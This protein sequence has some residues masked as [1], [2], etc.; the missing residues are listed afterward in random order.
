MCFDHRVFRQV[1]VAAV[2]IADSLQAEPASQSIDQFVA[3]CYINPAMK[4][5]F[6]CATGFLKLLYYQRESFNALRERLIVELQA[7]QLEPELS[8]VPCRIG[9][10]FKGDT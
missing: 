3:G 1:F 4:Q 8:I 9:K 6:R 7:R 2:Q 10:N 5:V